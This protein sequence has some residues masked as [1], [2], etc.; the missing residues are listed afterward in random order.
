MVV[1]QERCGASA[2]Q[3]AL[4]NHPRA[5][6]HGDV[7]HPRDKVRRRAHEAYFGPDPDPDGYPEYCAQVQ[8]DRSRGNPV[9]YLDTQVFARN[10]REEAAVGV[11]L[12]YPHLW[13]SDLWEYLEDRAAREDLWVIHVRR[14]P[15]ACLV[16]ARQAAASR[17]RAWFEGRPRP[18]YYP[19]RVHV[20]PA[21]FVAYARD[22]EA[23]A[24]RVARLCPEALVVEYRDLAFRPRPTLERAFRY[25]ELPPSPSARPA[26]LRLPNHPLR[27]RVANWDELYAAVPRNLRVYLD[28][29]LV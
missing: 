4:A 12:L 23:D 9:R 11:K 10:L 26:V 18:A 21:E 1:G 17:V 13:H 25:L 20:D 15:L 2:L 6:C 28:T 22:H 27:K 7:L 29:D 3:T 19:A 16:S 8:L 5:H 24:R 14:N